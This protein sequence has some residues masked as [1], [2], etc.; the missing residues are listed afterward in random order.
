LTGGVQDPLGVGDGFLEHDQVVE[1]HRVDHHRAGA[2]ATQL[3]QVRPVGVPVAR[4]ALGVD[5][6]R[7]GAGG[8]PR[9]GVGQFRGRGDRGR[10][11][12]TRS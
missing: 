6:D 10:C 2:L 9:G 4:G 3:H 8:E 7:A 5:R 11:P 12:V 1:P